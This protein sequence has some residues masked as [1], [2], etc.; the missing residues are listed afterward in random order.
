MVEDGETGRKEEKVV[1]RKGKYP[2]YDAEA[3]FARWVGEQVER[4]ERV[5]L[6]EC[7]VQMARVMNANSMPKHIRVV[8]GKM[9]DEE[10]EKRRMANEYGV[11]RREKKCSSANF[12]WKVWQRI[13]TQVPEVKARWRKRT[14]WKSRM[15]G[16]LNQCMMLGHEDL[17]ED[18]GGFIEDI[19]GKEFA[20]S[21]LSSS[22]G[23]L[24]VKVV[25]G[26]IAKNGTIEDRYA[27]FDGTFSS[28][29]E[30]PRISTEKTQ[31]SFKDQNGSTASLSQAEADATVFK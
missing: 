1:V 4:F 21:S 31:H 10:I 3:F 28:E 24:G 15:V 5:E 19:D 20:T 16:N 9:G 2:K 8:Q 22:D 11:T 13:L 18:T 30:W 25:L 23:T 17:L 29:A 27:G 26:Y 7:L 6:K 12:D 14:R